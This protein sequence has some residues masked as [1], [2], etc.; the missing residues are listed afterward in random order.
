M[1]SLRFTVEA[2]HVSSKCAEYV[3][4]Y[5]YVNLVMK[6]NYET[7]AICSKSCLLC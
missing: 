7:S 2:K 3:N 4:N 6:L 5:D 1:T